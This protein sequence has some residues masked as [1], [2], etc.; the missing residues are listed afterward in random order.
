M[1]DFRSRLDYAGNRFSLGSLEQVTG[2]TIMGRST[3]FMQECP[4][5][6]RNLQIRIEYLGKQVACLHCDA[7]FEACDPASAAYPPMKSGLALLQRADELLEMVAAAN[8]RNHPERTRKPR[9]T[10]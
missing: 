10:P 9:P 2:G 5:C 4:T 3:Y 6:G 8:R 7:E 1:V